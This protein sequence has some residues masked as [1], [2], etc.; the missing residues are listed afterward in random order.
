MQPFTTAAILLVLATP[1]FAAMPH[2]RICDWAQDHPEQYL[3]KLWQKYPEMRGGN[4]VRLGGRCT[5]LPDK[6]DGALGIGS[7]LVS[8]WGAVDC[9]YQAYREGKPL[10]AN[11]YPDPKAENDYHQAW[12][13]GWTTAK[14]SCTSGKIPDFFEPGSGSPAPAALGDTS[15][16]Q[17]HDYYDNL[18]SS[19]RR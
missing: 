7:S 2:H 10:K 1:A 5:R 11:P 12:W 14:R 16:G 13:N 19:R 4:A 3:R 17:M 9:G 6:S 15:I 18:M 8:W